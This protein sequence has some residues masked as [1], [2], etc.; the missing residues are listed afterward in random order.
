LEDE[1]AI[2]LTVKDANGNVVRHVEGPVTAGF[3][4]VAWDLRYP[5]LDPWVPEDQR[6][7]SYRN[8]AGVLVEPGRYTVH[9]ARRIDGSLE[10]LDQM[11]TFAVKSIRQPTLPG[12]AQ[13]DRVAFSRRVDELSRAVKGS[14]A[15]ID[16]VVIAVDAIKEATLQSTANASLYEE[17][18]SIS[19]RARRLK[20]RLAADKAREFMGDTTGPV[21]ISSRLTAAGFGAR[22]TAYGPTA[23][24]LR[25][26]EIAHEEFAEV[27]RALDRLIDTEFRVLKNKL[28]AAGVPWT[29]GRGV[30]VAN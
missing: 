12:S 20:N 5:T 17:A 27:G 1:P 28:D 25:S 26:L 18:N 13:N 24:Q 29:P 22:S 8:P 9:L 6:Q 19:Q 7:E 15:A 16:E 4:R 21:P 3:H 14:V 10:N 2:V 30:P 23:T 11:Q